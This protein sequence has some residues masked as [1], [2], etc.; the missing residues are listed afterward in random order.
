MTKHHWVEDADHVVVFVGGESAA[1][2][3]YRQQGGSRRGF[4]LMSSTE[5]VPVV[6]AK[7]SYQESFVPIRTL[8]ALESEAAHLQ[9]LALKHKTLQPVLE[10]IQTRLKAY[11][12]TVWRHRY[13]VK[14]GGDI[15]P[16]QAA[17]SKLDPKAE[18]DVGTEAGLFY[19]VTG[20]KATDLRG[21]ANVGDVSEFG[22]VREGVEGRMTLLNTKEDVQWLREVHVPD[23]PSWVKSA[24]IFGNED[25]PSRIRAYRDEDPNLDDEFTEFQL[26]EDG[27]YKIVVR[28]AELS[29][30]LD[31]LRTPSAESS[32]SDRYEK[33]KRS[34]LSEFNEQHGKHYG[35]RVLQEDDPDGDPATLVEFGDN[36]TAYL[37][38]IGGTSYLHEA[39]TPWA[40]SEFFSESLK[41]RSVRQQ[42]MLSILNGKDTVKAISEAASIQQAGLHWFVTH[43][44]FDTFEEAEVFYNKAGSGK[45]KTVGEDLIRVTYPITKPSGLFY[46]Q[47]EVYARTAREGMAGARAALSKSGV[48]VASESFR[49]DS[50]THT[51]NTVQVLFDS[52]DEADRVYRK[53]GSGS[54]IGKDRW[55]V[56]ASSPLPG[57]GSGNESL[58]EISIFDSDKSAARIA[59][60]SILKSLGVQVASEA[61][62][63]I[64]PSTLHWFSFVVKFDTFEEAKRMHSRL[65]SRSQS[66][67]IKDHLVHADVLLGGGLNEFGL[68][69][70]SPDEKTALEEAKDVIK[71]LEEKAS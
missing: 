15:A 30:E 8:R 60:G 11:Q 47:I 53:L 38:G 55:T 68:S 29:E 3:Y 66:I 37:H 28:S 34:A 63:S 39:V 23:L 5:E 14:F 22:I 45:S 2:R 41:G 13:S 17:I 9:K 46:V 18:F 42:V 59:V 35:K 7:M 10:R 57:A 33:W 31:R 26:Q 24:V 62:K 25:S 69:V 58:V 70:Y 61:V 40:E 50:E 6:G 64:T 48:E 43:V 52:L 20:L 4:H 54:R 36:G 44:N 1:L 67:K 56:Q 71:L 51:W 27:S 21:V 12:E 32:W 49:F 19:V 16:V 65:G